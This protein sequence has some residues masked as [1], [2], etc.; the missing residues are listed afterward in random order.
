MEYGSGTYRCTGW[1][2]AGTAPGGG[3]GGGWLGE[4]GYPNGDSSDI[5]RINEQTLNN[6]VTVVATDNASA[7][8]PLSIAS[9]VT[10][11]VS[12]G[13]TFVVI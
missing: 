11:T 3:G 12:S 1:S 4:T 9:G 7:T 8:G 13:A 5:I 2:L 6:S 10:I